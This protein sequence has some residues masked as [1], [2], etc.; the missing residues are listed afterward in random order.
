M[1][2]NI[3]DTLR[4]LV[5]WTAPPETLV[6]S[7]Y[8]DIS[9]GQ[10]ADAVDFARAS[11]EELLEQHEDS[12]H[13]V[14]FTQL[15]QRRLERL[16]ETVQRARR[17]D[18]DGLAI[19]LCASPSLSVSVRLRFPF[20][21]QALVGRDPFLRHL[22]R[23]AEEYERSICVALTPV[24]AQICE[25]HIGD[26]VSVH[27]VAPTGRREM[28]REV[29]VRLARMVRED[30]AL[31]V[32]LFGAPAD[33]EVLEAVLS[34]DVLTRI[35]DRVDQVL[36][37]G[38]P[39]FL[40]AVHRSLQDYERR[41]EEQGVAGLLRLR[42]EEQEVAVGLE[43][44]LETINRGRIKKLFALQSF[45]GTGW[46]CDVCDYLGSLPAPPFCIACGASVSVVPLEEHLLDQAA[47][48]GAEIETVYE[49]AALADVGGIGALID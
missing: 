25:I 2:S 39:E 32:I 10:Q 33:L 11:C 46:L 8:L 19:F 34:Q 20:E 28:P 45:E 18:Y 3:Y 31:H 1:S 47:A 6:L 48:C 41:S 22:L 7:L 12:P 37:P 27:D 26:L 23:V 36:S 42:Q 16:P 9:P 4:E 40:R 44:T 21:N 15:V 49:S 5:E 30:P 14:A 17:A 43:E 38:Q 35:I 29:A 13:A 24:A